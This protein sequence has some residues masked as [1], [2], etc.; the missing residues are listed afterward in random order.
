M[1]LMNMS[2]MA[3]VIY[4]GGAVGLFAFLR[5]GSSAF[6]ALMF[7]LLF[8]I[9]GG[10]ILGLLS[11]IYT[12][13][14]LLDT[15]WKRSFLFV[16]GLTFIASIA[17]GV[18]HPLLGAIAASGVQVWTGTIASKRYRLL[19]AQMPICTN[20]GYDLRR[21]RAIRCP[22]CGTESDYLIVQANENFEPTFRR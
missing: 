16:F 6:D 15:N 18:I 17:F 10:S 4:G 3:G 21:L 8:G 12:I 2:I 9:F 13:P 14:L 7:G 1:D 5:E 20:C 22:E 11:C 19:D